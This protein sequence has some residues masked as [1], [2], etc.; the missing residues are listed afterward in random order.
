[1]VK[2]ELCTSR[3]VHP[4]QQRLRGIETSGCIG[5]SAPGKNKSLSCSCCMDKPSDSEAPFSTCMIAGG[6]NPGGKSCNEVLDPLSLGDC[7][8]ILL[9]GPNLIHS[10]QILLVG[11]TKTSSFNPAQCQANTSANIVAAHIS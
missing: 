5:T 7:G 9:F 8:N 11:L 6:G 1:M 2:G 4:L 3:H 10:A